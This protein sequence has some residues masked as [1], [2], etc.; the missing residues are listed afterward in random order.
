MAAVPGGLVINDHLNV[1]LVSRL[2][3]PAGRLIA[4]GKRLLHHDV[5]MARSRGFDD[6]RM[7]KGARECSDGLRL[8]VVEHLAQVREE[9]IRREMILV[10]VLLLQGSVWIV[11]AD[12]L[13]V[14]SLADGVEEAVDVTVV[15]AGDRQT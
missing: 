1:A 3:Y 15:Q 11:D 13:Y 9:E 5:N 8:S 2:L 6:H 7:V 10:A 12:E 4:D 14:L